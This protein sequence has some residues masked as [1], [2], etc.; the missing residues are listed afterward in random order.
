MSPPDWN[1]ADFCGKELLQVTLDHSERISSE[2]LKKV[3]E[4]IF[5]ASHS[6]IRRNMGPGYT[7]IAIMGTYVTLVAGQILKD[8]QIGQYGKQ[9]LKKIHLSI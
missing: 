3:K 4:G 2:L 1:W 5:H 6:I 8:N 7:N 9:R